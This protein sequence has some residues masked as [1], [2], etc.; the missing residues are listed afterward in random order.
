VIVDV[1]EK[2]TTIEVR[3]LNSVYP[4]GGFPGQNSWQPRVS[5]AP[6]VVKKPSVRFMGPSPRAKETFAR[7][8]TFVTCSGL[9]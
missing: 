8:E 6:V 1:H 4:Q 2:T 9:G 3:I 7:E 5:A